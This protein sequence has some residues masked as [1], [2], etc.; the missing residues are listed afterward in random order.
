MEH[1]NASKYSR[2][3]K[4]PQI[5][6]HNAAQPSLAGSPRTPHCINIHKCVTGGAGLDSIGK[7]AEI[8]ISPQMVLLPPPPP[9]PRL[10][11]AAP[12]PFHPFRLAPLEPGSPLSSEALK[13]TTTTEMSSMLPTAFAACINCIA[14]LCCGGVTRRGRGTRMEGCDDTDGH[15]FY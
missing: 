15:D 4:L 6:P 7:L 11:L 5:T 9:P 3:I 12:I 10:A 1:R 2:I 8:K 14:T 13:V